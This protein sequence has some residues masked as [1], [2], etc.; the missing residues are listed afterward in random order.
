MVWSA[1]FNRFP[2][3][4]SLLT[5][6]CIFLLICPNVDLCSKSQPFFCHVSFTTADI[7]NNGF[8]LNLKSTSHCT[9]LSPESTLYT[10]N[11]SLSSCVTRTVSAYR[12]VF[13]RI[14]DTQEAE[15]LQRNNTRGDEQIL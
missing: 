9:H 14:D 5:L 4:G 13:R 1:D 8:Y 6:T 12:R 15:I 7:N 11:H 10:F 2:F 3:G